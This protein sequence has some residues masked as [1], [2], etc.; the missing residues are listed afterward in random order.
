MGIN[1]IVTRL[2]WRQ[3][4]RHSG[5][6]NA[7]NQGVTTMDEK[8]AIGT[9]DA[10]IQFL[11]ALGYRITKPKPNVNRS[12]KS[13][14]G[15]SFVATF[16][17][18]NVTR[19]SVCTSIDKLDFW[20]GVRLARIAIESRTKRKAPKLVAAHFEQHGRT[21]ATFNERQLAA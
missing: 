12:R 5:R 3:Q 6:A 1:Y 10:A 20:R 9:R 4:C 14:L 21:L 7:D 2:E 19:M 13:Q 11:K 8:Q 16:A 18:G 15:P 17:D